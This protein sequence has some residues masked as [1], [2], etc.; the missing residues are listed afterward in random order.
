MPITDAKLQKLGAKVIKIAGKDDVEILHKVKIRNESGGYAYTYQVR[1]TVKGFAVPTS[2]GTTVPSQNII[3]QQIISEADA[4]ITTPYGTEISENER[5]RINGTVY[6]T[7]KR[8]QGSFEVVSRY[9][10]VYTTLDQS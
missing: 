4:I 7:V 2:G 1:A 9:A 5:I 8:F 3:G 10:A 6:R